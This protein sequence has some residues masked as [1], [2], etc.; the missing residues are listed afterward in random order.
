MS[1]II[2]S[3]ETSTN[4]CSVSLFK[5]NKLLC[6]KEDTNREHSSLL[7]P[8]VQQI[9]NE[10]NFE[11]NLIDAI[12]L[13]IGPG[14][15]TGLRIGLSFTKGIAFSLNKPIIPV[16]TIESLNDG[17]NDSNY[18]IAIHAYSDYYFIQEYK[19]NIKFNKPFFDKI[20][21]INYTNNLYGYNLKD[22]KSFIEVFPS[23]IKIA[24][25]AYKNYN[26]YKTDNIKL[27]TPNYI[28]PIQFKD[29]F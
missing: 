28:K 10:V 29:K 2:L 26:E 6:L 8:F 21:N 9:F 4:I 3:I 14:S 25:I 5:S 16:D 7:A 20:T 24:N 22:C 1:K 12:A 27:I 15:Y 23:S 18:M 19:N 17:I 11:I 13:S